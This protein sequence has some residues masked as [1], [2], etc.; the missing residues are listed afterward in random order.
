MVG[1][2]DIEDSLQRLDKLTQEEAR[3]ASAELM[4][5]SHGIDDK[6]VGVDEGVKGI[7]ERVQEIKGDVR[8]VGSK[9]EDVNDRVQGVKHKLDGTNRSSSPRPTSFSL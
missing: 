4:K 9:A 6:L 2:T 1:N 5:I 7:D 8:N 3:M